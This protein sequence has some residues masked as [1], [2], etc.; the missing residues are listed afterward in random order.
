MAGPAPSA[1]FDKARNRWHG[2]MVEF[3]KASSELAGFDIEP[4]VPPPWLKN[5]SDAFF[6]STSTHDLCVY[7]TALGILDF[8]VSQYAV[9]N[10]RAINANWMILSQEDIWLITQVQGIIVVSDFNS[11]VEKFMKSFEIIT[12]PFERGTW[13]FLIFF[14]IP[15]MGITF[16]IHE[17]GRPGSSF[18]VGEIEEGEKEDGTVE[19]VGYREISIW[20]HV[21]TGIYNSFLGV[22]RGGYEETVVTNGGFLHL[23]GVS[24]FIMTIIA[25]C[26]SCQCE[27]VSFWYLTK[28]VFRRSSWFLSCQ[29]QILPTWLQS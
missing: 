12:R 2:P 29:H 5:R 28:K 27:N 24:F 25:V 10:T 17:Y 1:Y 9:T 15:F 18:P 23:L 26:K 22:L 14:F 3:A 8:C 19:K 21:R 16:I 13:V 6:N 11:L 7:A 20:E 4:T